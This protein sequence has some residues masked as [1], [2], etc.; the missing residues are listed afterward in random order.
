VREIFRRHRL[1]RPLRAADAAVY[2]EPAPLDQPDGLSVPTRDQPRCPSRAF[3][4]STWAARLISDLLRNDSRAF[5][6]LLLLWA[7]RGGLSA[8]LRGA[9]TAVMR[10][11][12]TKAPRRAARASPKTASSEKLLALAPALFPP[13]SPISKKDLKTDAARFLQWSQLVILPPS[14]HLPLQHLHLPARPLPFLDDLHPE[15]GQ[16]P[17]YRLVGFHDQRYRVRFVFPVVSIEGRP[18]W[19][20]ERPLTP[21]TGGQQI[22]HLRLPIFVLA[23]RWSSRQLAARRAAGMMWMTSARA[24]SSTLG[25]ISIIW[26]TAWPTRNSSRKRRQLGARLQPGVTC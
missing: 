25:V 4:P 10:R 2:L 5:Y 20:S 19:F 13:P 22:H 12:L 26:A 14:H 8:F 23:S 15:R 16:L 3:S 24:P 17:Q 7:K 21:A 1:P 18:F 11:G 9:D 6:Y